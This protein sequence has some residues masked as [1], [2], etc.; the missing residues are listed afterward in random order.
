MQ[1]RD[2]VS[3]IKVSFLSQS[4][5]YYMIPVRGANQSQNGRAYRPAICHILQLLEKQLPE[6]VFPPPISSARP[7]ALPD[8]GGRGSVASV[9]GGKSGLHQIAK[10]Q[11]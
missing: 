2:K 9:P 4:K 6:S 1:I 7:D 3:S 11:P 8:P 5:A 10:P